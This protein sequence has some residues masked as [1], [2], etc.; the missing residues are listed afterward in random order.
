M[1]SG[2]RDRMRERIV[3][4]GLSSLQEH[5]ILEYLLY[6]L[7]PRK[8]TNPLA[9]LLIKEF[10][11][12]KEVFDASVERLLKVDGV[13]NNI[14]VFLNSVS[15]LSRIYTSKSVGEDILLNT[16]GKCVEYI[17]PFMRTL[18]KEEV[19]VILKNSQGKLIKK[20]L[21][22]KGIVNESSLYIREVTDIALKNEA[23]SVVMVH[24]H[25]S[26]VAEPSVA[27]KQITEQVA[28]MLSLIS[29]NLDDHIIIT[30]DSHFSFRSSGLLE[31]IEN[32]R[33]KIHNGKIKDVIY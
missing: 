31:K 29:I 9:H 2:H 26:N 13:T 32:S 7:V 20:V 24:N 18:T 16:T 4:N 11:S 1:H 12:L 23:S 6:S 21:V 14:A 22:A 19:Y 3:E 28:I 25:P 27:D 15:D 5:E 33:I 30:K 17:S 10:G 8:D